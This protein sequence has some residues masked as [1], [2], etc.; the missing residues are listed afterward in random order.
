MRRFRSAA[1]SA[2]SGAVMTGTSV[3]VRLAPMPIGLP[4][5]SLVSWIVLSS[6]RI[7]T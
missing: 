5:A 1:T 2:A 6:T 3:A 4:P 7:T